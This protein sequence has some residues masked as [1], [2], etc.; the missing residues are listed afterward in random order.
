MIVISLYHTKRGIA[1]CF[2]DNVC[3]HFRKFLYISAISL[4]YWSW[5]GQEAKKNQKLS[6]KLFTN[7]AGCGI[8]SLVEKPPLAQPG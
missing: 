3:P 7:P 6:E 4:H 1:N 5:C 8:I 2:F